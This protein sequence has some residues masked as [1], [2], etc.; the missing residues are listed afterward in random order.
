MRDQ[1]EEPAKT[2]SGGQQGQSQQGGGG[3]WP[4]EGADEPAATT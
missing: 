3:V 2:A 4:A 1:P